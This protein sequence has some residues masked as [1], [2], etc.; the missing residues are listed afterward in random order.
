MNDVR[1][2]TY[3]KLFWLFLFGSL[4][5]VLIEG[6]WCLVRYKHWETHVVTVF[7][8]L[9]V[10]Y[11]FG[12]V[13]C[14]IFTVLL[15]GKGNI[16]KFIVFA[17]V[18]TVVEFFAGFILE[19]GLNMRAWDYSGSFLNLKGYVS[20]GMTFMW[21]V[22]GLAFSYIVPVIDGVFEKIRTQPWNIACT[23]LSVFLAVDVVVSTMSFIRWSKRHEGVAPRNSVERIIDDKF[24]DSF[25]EKRFCEWYFI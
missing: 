17:L 24:S 8:P 11:G 16:T 12:M 15:E 4:I 19:H 21:G 3:P 6:L 25:M 20:I 23:V 22:L 13:G 10:L 9:C 14:Y 7:E 18:G 2:I 5:G 1:R